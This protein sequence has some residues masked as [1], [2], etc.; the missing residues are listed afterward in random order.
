MALELKVIEGK[1]LME[2]W[3]LSALELLYTTINQH[4]T[5]VQR[6]PLVLEWEAVDWGF[7]IEWAQN[8]KSK[9]DMSEFV[10]LLS[11]VVKLEEQSEGLK[12]RNRPL[13]T[14]R[15]L[16]MRWNRSVVEVREILDSN[17]AWAVDATGEELKDDL[18]NFLMMNQG[19]GYADMLFKLDDI[20]LIE[21]DYPELQGGQQELPSAVEGLSRSQ[22]QSKESRVPIFSFYKNGEFWKIGEQGN[23]RSFKDRK[24]L[25]QIRF[26]I[27]KEGEEIDVATVYNLGQVH[28]EE[29]DVNIGHVPTGVQLSEIDKL[30]LSDDD[31]DDIGANPGFGLE[32]LSQEELDSASVTEVRGM[33]GVLESKLSLELD[34]EE[35]LELGNQ[36]KSLKDHLRKGHKKHGARQTFKSQSEENLRTAVLKSINKA[37]EA[38]HAE[39]PGLDKFINK[40]TIKTGYKCSYNQN[41][42]SQAKWNLNPPI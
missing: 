36:L 7:I 27:E 29:N 10:F 32:K 13:I 39:L 8:N 4:I 2:R 12:S 31:E 41:K 1:K 34:Q 35:R 5:P 21:E 15:E 23:E 26:L 19:V 24:G 17:S 38:L 6:Y 33:I 14:G 37:I 9:I 40:D 30:G 22:D 42:S 20:E 3:S 28:I 25:S 16:V 18:I 11:E